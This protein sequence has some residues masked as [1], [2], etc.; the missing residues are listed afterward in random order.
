MA[1]RLVRTNTLAAV[2]AA[3][4]LACGCASH[5]VNNSWPDD[6]NLTY[7]AVV[8][9]AAAPSRASLDRLKAYFQ[10]MQNL[11][12]VTNLEDQYIGCIECASLSTSPPPNELTFIFYRQHRVDL[13]AFITAF[14]RVQ[15]SAIR[16]PN[17]T[18]SFDAKA[19]P[20]AACTR[21]PPTCYPAPACP[22]TGC[23][24]NRSAPGC[25]TCPP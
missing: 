8:K 21:P 1:N 13:Y 7:R 12:G 24:A 2:A 22:V 20:S 5:K 15:A 17:F 16:D 25:Q 18:L 4:L 19:P 6:V 11:V 10:A 23:D 14:E 9:T 3:S